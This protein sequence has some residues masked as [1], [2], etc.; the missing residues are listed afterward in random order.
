MPALIR[1]EYRASVGL[2]TIVKTGDVREELITIVDDND[3]DLVVMG[4]HGRKSFEHFLLGSTTE[5]VIRKIHVPILTVSH[6]GSG[7]EVHPPEHVKIN[8][9]V[10]ATDLSFNGE[11]GLRYAAEVARTFKAELIV[12]HV[13]DDIELGANLG[14]YAPD[15]S[16][17][18]INDL[19][20][21]RD[22]IEA[23]GATDLHPKAVTLDGTPYREITKF[24]KEQNVDLIVINLQ[25]KGFLER[26]MLG[27][28]AER[29]IRSATVPVLSLP[30]SQRA[31]FA[32]NVTAL[33]TASVTGEE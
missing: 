28:T 9:I 1:D 30:I 3:I 16:A 14:Q 2:K 5:K 8:R 15:R 12:L 31:P 7:K 29:V 11:V 19:K 21:L 17:L 27:A 20:R 6:I 13:M 18:R 26:A 22:F 25:S 32:S 23:E 24:V 4:T 33:D 10:Y